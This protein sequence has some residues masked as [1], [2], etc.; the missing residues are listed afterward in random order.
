MTCP[1]PPISQSPFPPTPLPHTPI[2]LGSDKSRYEEIDMAIFN[3]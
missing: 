3:V 1:S 2:I